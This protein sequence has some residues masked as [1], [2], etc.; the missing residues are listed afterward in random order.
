[1]ELLTLITIGK[2]LVLSKTR[3][4]SFA[5]IAAFSWGVVASLGKVLVNLVIVLGSSSGQV[6]LK[7]R[8]TR[9]IVFPFYIC[10]IVI[11]FLEALH[12]I[13]LFVPAT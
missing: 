3:V 4:G 5:H 8:G 7:L 9:R 11:R 12:L 2:C 10:R 1:M 6:I 13:L